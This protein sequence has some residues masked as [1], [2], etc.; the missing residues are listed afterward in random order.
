MIFQFADLR[1]LNVR[2]LLE[3]IRNPV[4]PS[5]VPDPDAS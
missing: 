5:A 2:R 1:K 3:E 4:F